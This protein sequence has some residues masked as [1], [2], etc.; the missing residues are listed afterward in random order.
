[1][2][3][4]GTAWLPWVTSLIGVLHTHGCEIFHVIWALILA[5]TAAPSVITFLALRI[6]HHCKL[7]AVWERSVLSCTTPISRRLHAIIGIV[8]EFTGTVLGTEEASTC[9]TLFTLW[10]AAIETRFLVIFTLFDR[11]TFTSAIGPP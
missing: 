11:G 1:M 2:R 9:V 5:I 3:W 6:V 8:L 10:V 4:V 7:F